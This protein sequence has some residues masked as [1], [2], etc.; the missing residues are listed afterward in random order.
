MLRRKSSLPNTKRVGY[1]TIIDIFT[2][3]VSSRCMRGVMSLLM[4]ICMCRRLHVQR[5]LSTRDPRR[6]FE[7]RLTKRTRRKDVVVLMG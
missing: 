6:E 7:S 2:P 1:V 5:R 4:L 3:C